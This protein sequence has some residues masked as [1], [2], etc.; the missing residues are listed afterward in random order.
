M[1][2]KIEKQIYE[3]PIALCVCVCVC[4]G[5]GGSEWVGCPKC[6]KICMK[7]VGHGEIRTGERKMGRVKISTML[8]IQ[9]H[10]HGGATT[11]NQDPQ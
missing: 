10:L 11:Q 9:L 4:G 5:G 2:N 3:G 7:G 6:C 8:T 1:E